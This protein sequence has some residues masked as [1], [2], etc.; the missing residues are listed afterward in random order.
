MYNPPAPG[1][2]TTSAATEMVSGTTKNTAA[3]NHRVT[4]TGPAWAASG[5]QRVDTT[6]VYGNSVRSRRPSSR[7][8][9]GVDSVMESLRGVGLDDSAPHGHERSRA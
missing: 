1:C 2:F 9:G 3:S 8:S 5:I 7:L 4:D 6:H